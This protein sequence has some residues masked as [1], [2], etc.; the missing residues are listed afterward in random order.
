M[1][2]ENAPNP[3]DSRSQRP[4]VVDPDGSLL[5]TD[6]LWESLFQFL[7]DRAWKIFSLPIWIIKGKAFLR[8]QLALN[9]DIDVSHLPTNSEVVEYVNKAFQSGREVILATASDKILADRI[10]DHFGVFSTVLASD[11]IIN[12]RGK[13]KLDAVRIHLGENIDFD[14]IGNDSED[15]LMWKAANSV[16]LVG[17]SSHLKKKF[18]NHARITQTFSRPHFGVSEF[19]RLLRVH[20]WAK[21]MLLFL[22]LLLAHRLFDFSAI[23]TIGISFLSFS[24]VA[25][26]NYIINDLL[27]LSDDRQHPRKIHRILASGTLSIVRGVQLSFLLFI[28]GTSLAVIFLPLQFLGLLALY[29]FAT[30]TYSILLKRVMIIDVLLLAG[31]YSLRIFAGGAVLDIP[32]SHWLISFSVFFFLGL[33]FLKRFAEL[34]LFETESQS[35]SSARGYTLQDKSLLRGF[36]TTSGFLSVLVL[37]LYVTGDD[38]VVLYRNP[39][40]LWLLSPPLLYWIARVWFVAQRGRMHDDPVVFTIRDPV[41]YFVGLIMITVIVAAAL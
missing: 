15:L 30:T 1:M 38:V 33:G 19:I 11:G 34:C 13:K 24:T 40:L 29:V 21:N 10:A 16:C 6:I 36:G 37:A 17:P 26:A 18:S 22:P 39:E 31:L 7:R 9:A 23:V 14:Y 32:I 4:L 3:D 27:D 8:R 5:S 41:S 12:L 35:V 2:V 28:V 25:S 20:H